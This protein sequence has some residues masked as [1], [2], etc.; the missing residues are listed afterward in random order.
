MN[1]STPT[2]NQAFNL[3]KQG[4]CQGAIIQYHT[5]LSSNLDQADQAKCHELLAIAYAQLKQ[6]QEA[7]LHFQA[8]LKLTPDSLSLKNNIA[9]CY[10]KTG[11]PQKATQIYLDILKHHPAQ[12]VT[13]N[14]LASLYIEQKNFNDATSHLLKALCLRP[15]YADAY[16]NLGICSQSIGN[17]NEACYF[18]KADE[19]GHPKASYNLGLYYETKSPND[20]KHY[21]QKSLTI[22]PDDA[23]THHGLARVLL[24][25]DDDQEA[26]GHFIQAQ[27]QDPT[28]PHLMENIASYYHIKGQF[29]NAIEYWSKAPRT[30]ENNLDIQYNIAVSYHYANR[31]TEAL[32]YFMSILDV[33]PNHRNAHMNVAA[34]ALQN[35]QKKSAIVHYEQALKQDPSNPEIKYILGALKQSGETISQAPKDYVANLFDQYA[36]HYNQHLTNMLKYQLPEKIEILLHEHYK[37]K[38]ELAILDLGCGTG[39]FGNILR[40]F[41]QTLTGVDLSQ[42]MLNKAGET[43]LYD[44]LLQIDAIEHLDQSNNYNLII[45]AELFPYIGDPKPLLKAIYNALATNGM[46]IFSIES[47]NTDDIYS[48]SEN[49]RFIHNPTMLAAVIKDMG[50]KTTTIESTTLRLHQSQPVSGKLFLIQK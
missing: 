9:T 45:A 44:S 13:H 29:N 24:R 43:N 31:H 28:I 34:I 37:P 36:G 33:D 49:A 32:E 38:S 18:K 5:L 48:L 7:L 10:K 17:E 21:Y 8:G 20:A 6:Y 2:L 40:P 15:D 47:Q 19:Y 27:K 1:E 41:A 46:C 11:N 14:N 26:L 22:N 42:N 16:Y 23:Y 25:L 39:L 3:H 4:D 35:N 12:C 50:F 30:E